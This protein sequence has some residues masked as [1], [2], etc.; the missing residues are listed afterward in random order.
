M[1]CHFSQITLRRETCTPS[2]SGSII[3]E[4]KEPKVITTLPKFRGVVP[5]ISPAV[6]TSIR[7][8]SDNDLTELLND[9]GK[10]HIVGERLERR[11]PQ[12]IPQI[13][14]LRPKEPPKS[15]Q[16]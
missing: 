4:R 15:P 2:V 8:M 7:S 5:Y 16:A 9:V 10:W 11:E 14:P 1:S 3:V 12:V 13:L 6:L